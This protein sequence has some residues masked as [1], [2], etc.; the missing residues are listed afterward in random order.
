MKDKRSFE[1]YWLYN[2]EKREWIE[3]DP[4]KIPTRTQEATCQIRHKIYLFGG[5]WTQQ[6]RI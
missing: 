5:E 3:S 1:N 2:I 4:I 6:N